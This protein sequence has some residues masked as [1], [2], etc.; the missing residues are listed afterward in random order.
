[1]RDCLRRIRLGVLRALVGIS[2]V[3]SAGLVSAA[4]LNASLVKIFGGDSVPASVS[5]LKLMQDHLQKLSETLIPCTVG[6]RVG[7]AQGSGV[8]ISEDGYVLTAAHVVM[9]PNIDVTFVLHDGKTVKGKTLGMNRAIDAG[10]MK[11]TEEGKYP[12]VEMGTSNGLKDGQWCVATGHPGGYEK[13]RQPVVRFGRILQ[14]HESVITSDCTLV[15][16][17]SG[18]PLF[19]MEGKVIGINSRIAGPL[20][21]NMHVPVNTYRETWDRL[22]NAE[23]WGSLPGS[24]PFFGVQGEP[25]V[26]EARIAK[27]FPNTP[28]E[29][30]GIRVGDLVVEF[31]GKPIEE[32]A[33]LSKLVADRAPGDKVKVKVKRGEETLELEVTIGKRS[34]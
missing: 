12:H 22:K 10:L 8:I 19:D 7:P 5:E 17:D 34:E 29:K 4:E 28:A 1:M 24:A 13:G 11:I 20:N 27:V 25:D 33:A 3:F 6:V 9:R 15:G 32:F 30:A 21:A 2:L 14:N 26:K 31:D 16:G 23:V 18:G